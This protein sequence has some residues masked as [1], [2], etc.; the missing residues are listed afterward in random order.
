MADGGWRMA[1]GGKSASQLVRLRRPRDG[2]K[3]G[4]KLVGFRSQ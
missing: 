4:D 2:N 1:D 3:Y